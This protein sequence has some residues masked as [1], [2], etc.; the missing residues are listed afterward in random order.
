MKFHQPYSFLF[1][2]LSSFLIVSIG[3][4]VPFTPAYAKEKKLV[5]VLELR[6]LSKLKR[7]DVSALTTTI[8]QAA[9]HL[10]K[11]KFGL[12]TKENISV[13]LPPGKTIEDCE[14]ECDV[15]TARL[16]GA[17]YV[18]SGE[19]SKFGSFL[20]VNISLH[21]AIS[22]HLLGA[23]V[24]KQK[25]INELDQ[26]LLSETLILLSEL[27]P[28]LRERAERVRQG[29]IFEHFHQ[30]V[31]PNYSQFDQGKRTSKVG[32]VP[33]PPP[34]PKFPEITGDFNSADLAAFEALEVAKNKEYNHNAS[35]KQK[36]KAWKK[37]SQFVVF[38][39]L[40]QKRIQLWSNYLN[41]VQAHQDALQKQ[42]RALQKKRD[43]AWNHLE[44]II[45]EDQRR[46][47]KRR[48]QMSKDWKRLVRMLKL[49]VIPSKVKQNWSLGFI[50][51]YGGVKELNPYVEEP[52]LIAQ[53]NELSA[54]KRNAIVQESMSEL[55]QKIKRREEIRHQ[56][57]K[58]DPQRAHRRM[59]Q[60]TRSSS[61]SKKSPVSYQPSSY[62]N[63]P[64]ASSDTTL[65]QGWY[66]LCYQ[67][68]VSGVPTISTACRT[69]L[70]ACQALRVKV[71]E[72]SRIL[73][74]GSAGACVE[75]KGSTPWVATG[76]PKSV[77][78]PSKRAGSWWSPKGCFVSP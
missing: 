77:W 26:K 44:Q 69:S 42:Q 20:R 35:A 74:A 27:E 48:E 32:H 9:S 76:S 17:D 6:N 8:R 75:G 5:A 33:H 12:I 70:E 55:M 64:I 72:G 56:K 14:G 57:E 65:P 67:E 13:M 15:E 18:I 30:S 40:A 21:E 16:I 31:I 2:A 68:R 52:L 58:I 10:S 73:V 62:N 19:V 78:K 63:T 3:L 51:A 60:S 66:C 7:T 59:K 11:S 41:Q 29:I 54:D 37:V 46:E 28:S 53:I 71:Q 23:H 24:V 49:T 34:P 36:L 4:A 1:W 50:E 47:R 38:K 45:A 39:S 43:Q 22:G 25:K 61:I